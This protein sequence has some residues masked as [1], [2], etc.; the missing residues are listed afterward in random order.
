MLTNKVWPNE[1]GYVGDGKKPMIKSVVNGGYLYLKKTMVVPKDAGTD[2]VTNHKYVL[3][4][5]KGKENPEYK[6]ESNIKYLDSENPQKLLN[7]AVDGSNNK[8]DKK[9]K[10]KNKKE[11]RK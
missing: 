7:D 4:K 5:F 6:K 8:K 9:G 1:K 10:K 2:T 11:R 3:E